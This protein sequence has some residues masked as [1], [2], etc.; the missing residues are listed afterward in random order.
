MPGTILRTMGNIL[1]IFLRLG[2][3]VR[4]AH[5]LHSSVAPVDAV[6]DIKALTVLGGRPVETAV[7]LAYY[8]AINTL[9][10]C[11]APFYALWAIPYQ[12]FSAWG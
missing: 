6:A 2:V 11:R 4:I 12:H 1:P 10:A 9:Y 7:I 8:E 5:Y 3:K